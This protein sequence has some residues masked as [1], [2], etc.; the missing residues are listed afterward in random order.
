MLPD[1]ID[2]RVSSVDLESDVKAILEVLRELESAA[3][4]KGDFML[5][6][7]AVY[8]MGWYFY[9][10][11]L[12]GDLVKKLINLYGKEIM[13]MKGKKFE[14]KFTSWLTERLRKSNCNA[15]LKLKSQREFR[16]LWPWLLK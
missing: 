15:V 8:G 16:G 12:H 9:G 2:F 3:H 4:A 5:D 11:S 14:D 13:S 10:L 1:S 6:R 7:N